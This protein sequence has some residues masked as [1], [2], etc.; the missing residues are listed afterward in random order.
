MVK[1]VIGLPG[2][3]ISYREGV[4]ISMVIR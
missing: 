3:T 1:R 2:E 4:L